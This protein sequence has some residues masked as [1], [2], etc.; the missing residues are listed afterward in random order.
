MDQMP[1]NK[2]RF[3]PK[4]KRHEVLQV[5]FPFKSLNQKVNAV[6]LLDEDDVDEIPDEDDTINMKMQYFDQRVA[7]R[8]AKKN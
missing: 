4:I 6:P 5:L 8:R 2:D 3:K 7:E 1:K